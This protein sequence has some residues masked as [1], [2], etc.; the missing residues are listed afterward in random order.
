MPWVARALLIGVGTLG[1]FA[2]VPGDGPKARRRAVY[3]DSLPDGEGRPLAERWCMICHS[4]TLITQQ[5]KD[6]SGWDKTITQMEKWGV[7]LS[8]AEHDTLR[9]YLVA[10]P[11]PR[12]IK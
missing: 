6:S 8:P 5:A 4:A 12:T 9:A 7:T 11:G 1:L 3:A 2:A 10:H